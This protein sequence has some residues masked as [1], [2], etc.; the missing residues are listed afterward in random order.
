MK[1]T[2]PKFKDA[3]QL[4]EIGLQAIAEEE[5]QHADK[6]AKYNAPIK[7]KKPEAHI[8]IVKPISN[9]TTPNNISD[10]E[11]SSTNISTPKHE[12][13]DEIQRADDLL[14]KFDIIQARIRK[15]LENIR[16]QE[17]TRYNIEQ[18]CCCTV[19]TLEN[20][21][22]VQ[23]IMQEIAENRALHPEVVVD[24][25]IKQLRTEIGQYKNVV[26]H[27]VNVNEAVAKTEQIMMKKSIYCPGSCG[28]YLR[29]GE[30][31]ETGVQYE[32]GN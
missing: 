8:K 28:W 23:K 12:T 9:S 32:Q 5:K 11:G 17:K 30:K 3:S 10:V 26:K 16:N 29:M 22:I 13:A 14:Q 1:S 24:G 27:I 2:V 18:D 7:K 19:S 31:K 4:P 20:N 25:N 21:D 15:N 6:V